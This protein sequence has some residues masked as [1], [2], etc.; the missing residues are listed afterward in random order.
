[1]NRA[2]IIKN[3]KETKSV[4]QKNKKF[5]E[6]LFNKSKDKD[7]TK[8]KPENLKTINNKK[9]TKLAKRKKRKIRTRTNRV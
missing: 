7:K 9:T 8:D 2:K 6:K 4:P 1:M 3:K 5:K